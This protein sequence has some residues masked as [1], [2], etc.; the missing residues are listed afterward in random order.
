M[1]HGV[2]IG[3]SY[4]IQDTPRNL[5]DN[6]GYQQHRGLSVAAFAKQSRIRW[7]LS[8]KRIARP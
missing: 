1:A 4:K 5:A 6:G 2:N 7:G 3:L 8:A